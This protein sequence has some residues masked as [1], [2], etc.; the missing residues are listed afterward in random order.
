[1][2]KIKT[3]IAEVDMTAIGFGPSLGTF[4]L[5]IKLNR[6]SFWGASLGTFG[7]FI[8]QN[9]CYS[10]TVFR[11]LWSFHKT[12]LR[13]FLRT[14]FRDLWSFHKTEPW[15]YFEDFH[16]VNGPFFKTLCVTNVCNWTQIIDGLEILF[17]H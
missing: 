16:P 12:E 7:L 6:G 5:S 2:I 1:M 17:I 10:R 11:D 9:R 14:V 13:F 15:S 4:D 3:I 8:K